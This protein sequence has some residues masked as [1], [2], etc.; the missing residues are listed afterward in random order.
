MDDE[1]DELER[2]PHIGM[3]NLHADLGWGGWQQKIIREQ[4]TAAGAQHDY[5]QLKCISVATQ[6]Y[7]SHTA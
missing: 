2:S 6:E 7:N 1:V 4:H 5:L 3:T